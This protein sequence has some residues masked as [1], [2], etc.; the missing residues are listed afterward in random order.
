[1]FRLSGLYFAFL[2]RSAAFVESFPPLF[3]GEAGESS[4][5]LSG[6]E[7]IGEGQRGSGG[8]RGEGTLRQGRRKR[9]S[10]GRAWESGGGKRRDVEERRKERRG[11]GETTRD[12]K[13]RRGFFGEAQKVKGKRSRT[14]G[15]RKWGRQGDAGGRRFSGAESAEAG[16]LPGAAALSKGCVPPAAPSLDGPGLGRGRNGRVSGRIRLLFYRRVR[17][18]SGGGRL[19]SPYSGRYRPDLPQGRGP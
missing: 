14:G 1:M 5:L 15:I 3:W 11:G 8:K 17:C 9:E 4:F 10:C 7:R 18:V 13:E 12:A 6:M 19:Q 16:D 2:P